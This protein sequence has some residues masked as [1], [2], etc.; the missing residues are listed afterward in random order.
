MHGGYICDACVASCPKHIINPCIHDCKLHPGPLCVAHS[1]NDK[2]CFSRILSIEYGGY[3]GDS[4]C[5]SCR[6]H[7]APHA[8]HILPMHRPRLH[9]CPELF[10]D[11]Y[12][13]DGTLALDSKTLN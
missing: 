11:R 5:A 9:P 7:V 1:Y 8:Q 2:G 10:H 6:M 3:T 4:C 13:N 12:D